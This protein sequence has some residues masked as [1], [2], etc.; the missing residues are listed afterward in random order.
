VVVPDF[1]FGD[2][3]IK[4]DDPHFDR[5]SWKK[6]H[7]TVSFLLLSSNLW[8]WHEKL[9]KTQKEKPGNVSVC[10]SCPN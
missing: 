5:D 9:S 6:A 4:L 3:I 1:F 7:N 10:L 8:E 2:P